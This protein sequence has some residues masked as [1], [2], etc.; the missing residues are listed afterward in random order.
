MVGI[1][2][3]NTSNSGVG[4][5]GGITNHDY[6]IEPL[7]DQNDVYFFQKISSP[8]KI[9]SFPI[10]STACQEGLDTSFSVSIEMLYMFCYPSTIKINSTIINSMCFVNY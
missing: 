10:S 1:G 6:N 4:L 8:V 2:V 7:K 9:S 3:P 5:N